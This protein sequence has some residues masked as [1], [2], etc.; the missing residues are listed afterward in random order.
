MNKVICVVGPTAVGKTKISIE[1]AKHYNIDIYLHYLH[2][3]L[4]YL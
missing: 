2:S 4:G 3:F 1:I